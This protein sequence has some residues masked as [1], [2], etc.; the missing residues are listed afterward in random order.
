MVSVCLFYLCC[1]LYFCRKFDLRT[2]DLLGLFKFRFW[3]PYIVPYISRSCIDGLRKLDI[4]YCGSKNYII[5]LYFVSTR[6]AF[7][8]NWKLCWWLLV[9]VGVIYFC[10]FLISMSIQDDFFIIF[11]YSKFTILFFRAEFF[12]VCYLLSKCGVNDFGLTLELCAIGVYLW[13]SSF[14]LIGIMFLGL[15]WE[16]IFSRNLLENSTLLPT[17]LKS[18]DEPD[19]WSLNSVMKFLWPRSE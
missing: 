12:A 4:Y 8:V 13:D 19:E 2:C 6:T 9:F 7:F 1:F 3:V 18:H 10:V 17:A 5:L 15:F 11:G 16:F 14:C